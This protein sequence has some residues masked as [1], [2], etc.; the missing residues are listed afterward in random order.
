MCEPPGNAF[1]LRLGSGD[2]E[3][4]AGTLDGAAVMHAAADDVFNDSESEIAHLPLVFGSGATTRGL[5]TDADVE[6]L[7]EH[8]GEI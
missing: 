7:L 4:A 6:D 2:G 5:L 8:G 1:E 3:G